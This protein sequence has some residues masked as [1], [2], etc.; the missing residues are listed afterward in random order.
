[1]AKGRRRT[2]GPFAGFIRLRD[3]IDGIVVCKRMAHWLSHWDNGHAIPCRGRGCPFDLEG[4][5]PRD[6]WAVALRVESS[7]GWMIL[8]GGVRL[9]DRILVAVRRAGIY[10]AMLR[11]DKTGRSYRS[12]PSV[13]YLGHAPASAM[14]LTEIRPAAVLDRCR[15]ET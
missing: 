8:E 9:H 14:A 2:W 1:M 7:N 5:E 4:L 6:R 3:S 13:E 11:F 12:A 10:G 15:G